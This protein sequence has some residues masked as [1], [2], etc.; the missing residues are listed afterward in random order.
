MDI[1]TRRRQEPVWEGY[2]ADP[3]VFR[4]GDAWYAVGT[5]AGGASDQD[6]AYDARAA[7][8]GEY[9]MPLLRSDDFIRWEPVGE[10]LEP[11]ALR[12]GSEFWAPSVAEHDGRFYLY[13][14]VG[15][16]HQLRVAISARPE[17]PYRDHGPLIE[18]GL[19]TFAIDS[20][21][22]RDVDGTW[23]LF[24]ARDFLDH[25]DGI[26]PG[27]AMAMDRLVDMTRLAREERT[28]LRARHPWT[29]FKADREM[30]G[31]RWDWH[32][33]EGPCIVHHDGRYWCLFSGACYGNDSYGVD[34][35]V[36]DRITG[37]WCDVGGEREP[38][39]LRTI[40]GRL[41]GPGHNSV[42]TGP[43][44][45]EYLAFHAWNEAGTKRQM[46][47]DRLLWTPDGPRAAVMADAETT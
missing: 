39:V 16:G 6:H 12:L 38:R 3:F 24:Y 19:V 23:W 13:Y 36:A 40:P 29:L 28:V 14:S 10:A 22:F 2:C 17:G 32:T 44:G 21:P 7:V 45:H 8:P 4:A 27:T 31:K 47:L 18:P 46:H 30:Y 9:V 42:V 35:C 15:P 34:Y 33:I 1:T 5:G 11:A 41:I 25:G 43:D 37:P 20:H 26:H